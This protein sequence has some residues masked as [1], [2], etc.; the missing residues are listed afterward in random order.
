MAPYWGLTKIKMLNNGQVRL[1]C[2]FQTHLSKESPSEIK[3]PLMVS[4]ATEVTMS[5]PGPV[6][7]HGQLSL[8]LLQ[9]RVFQSEPTEPCWPWAAVIPCFLITI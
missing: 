3:L 5:M 8:A 1:G 6:A 2:N 9:P 4:M 7:Q